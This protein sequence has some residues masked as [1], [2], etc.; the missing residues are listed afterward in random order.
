MPEALSGKTILITREAQRS[1]GLMQKLQQ[2]GAECISFPV[3]RTTAPAD[4]TSCDRAL[5]NLNDYDWI[6]FSSVNGVR[7]F[8]GR[9]Q[10]KKI[11]PF[12]GRVAVIGNRTNE[13]LQSF[14][15]QADLQPREFSAQGLI[16]SFDKTTLAGK[17]ILLPTSDIAPDVLAEGLRALAAV[18][19][20]ITVYRTR[21]AENEGA[22]DLQR[23]IKENQ[24]DALLFFSPSAL[25]FFLG[26]MG[27]S[28]V[29]TINKSQIV[30]TAIGKSTAAAVREA[31][32]QV[33][34]LPGQSSQSS[35]IEALAAYFNQS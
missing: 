28:A 5:Q 9:A 35:L 19:E 8:L 10:Q 26:L 23:K 18:V 33:H 12:K 29:E 15:W 21:C 3:I 7:F 25:R 4:W 32:L 16:K 31:G 6:I 20:K 27:N 22:Y 30:L 24:I 1:T 34:I 17:R 13:E 14:G 11:Q 2:L